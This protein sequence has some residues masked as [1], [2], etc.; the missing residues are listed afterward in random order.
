MLIVCNFIVLNLFV[1]ILLSN[2]ESVSRT[3]EEEC[4]PVEDDVDARLARG[5][6]RTE[7]SLSG[8][9]ERSGEVAD[10]FTQPIAKRAPKTARVLQVLVAEPIRAFVNMLLS[11]FSRS[12]ITQSRMAE[13]DEDEEKDK[14]MD[15]EEL[16]LQ[17]EEVISVCLSGAA[18]YPK[19]YSGVP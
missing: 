16:S 18:S 9:F 2:V 7:R 19:P 15:L 12:A 1:A 11:L 14:Q 5:V 17:L 4:T 3:A 6:L 10:R 8:L 13:E